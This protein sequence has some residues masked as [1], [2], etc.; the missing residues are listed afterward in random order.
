MRAVSDISRQQ[1]TDLFQSMGDAHQHTLEPLS[2]SSAKRVKFCVWLVPI[3]PTWVPP[4]A[5]SRQP[6]QLHQPQ[7]V[8]SQP[9]ARSAPISQTAV[10]SLV[11]NQRLDILLINLE[12]PRSKNA[13][14]ART[15]PTLHLVVVYEQVS[16]RL[17]LVQEPLV[18][19]L[20]L[21][22]QRPQT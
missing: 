16:A 5:T 2:T 12:Q 1:A 17:F 4:L 6:V 11:C 22:A 21:P 9:F 7:E 15:N 19:Q 13:D 20:A 8:Q 14:L 18:K 3:S 10:K